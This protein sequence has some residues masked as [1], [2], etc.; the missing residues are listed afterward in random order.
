MISNEQQHA[1]DRVSDGLLDK[2]ALARKLD[3]SKRTIDG[4]M[5]TKRLPFIKISRTVRFVWSDVLA[6]LKRHEVN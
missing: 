5:A 2:W 6:A 1:V 3:V 4:W